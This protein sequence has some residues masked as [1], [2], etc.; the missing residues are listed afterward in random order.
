MSVSQWKYVD[1]DEEGTQPYDDGK[2]K[3]MGGPAMWPPGYIPTP[4]WVNAD[5][6]T[7]A[8]AYIPGHHPGWSGP[9]VSFFER[10]DSIP[11]WFSC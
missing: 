8:E 3:L 9:V 10:I 4:H 11:E 6:F 2:Y 7:S 1:R 5:Y